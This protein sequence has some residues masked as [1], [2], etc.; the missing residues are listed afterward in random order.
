MAVPITEPVWVR[1]D[2]APPNAAMAIPKSVTFTLPSGDSNTL[3]GFTSRWM[4]PLLWANPN[5]AATDKAI[6]AACSG[7]KG[8]SERSNSAKLWP[9]MYSMT[10]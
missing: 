1:F 3:P 8:P 4:T 6:S 10:M 9:S 2:S 5:A 7:G